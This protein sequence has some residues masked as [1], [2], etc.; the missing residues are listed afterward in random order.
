MRKNTPL[1]YIYIYIQEKYKFI[2]I[3]S[4]SR[5]GTSVFANISMANCP[6][7][8]GEVPNLWSND[9]VFLP[10][11]KPRGAYGIR[12]GLENG[13]AAFGK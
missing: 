7:Y 3:K 4:R 8:G 12:L 9:V 13:N 1:P 10:L 2:Y 5:D 6:N 11:I